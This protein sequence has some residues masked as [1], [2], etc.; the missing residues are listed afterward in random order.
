[1][2]LW[3]VGSLTPLWFCLCVSSLS[4]R[5]A[6]HYVYPQAYMQPNLVL[7]SQVASTMNPQYLDYSAAYAQYAA[8]AAYEQYPYSASPGFVGYTYATSPTSSASTAA[9]PTPGALHQSLPATASQA[10][11]TFIQYAPQQHVQPDRMQ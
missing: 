8:A 11:P 7:P 1:M 6:Q 9:A 10:P 4:G 5:L 3:C 2:R